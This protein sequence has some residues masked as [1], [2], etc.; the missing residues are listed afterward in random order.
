MI[1]LSE[2]TATLTSAWLLTGDEIYANKALE[3]LNA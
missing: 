1:R 2:I 3:Q